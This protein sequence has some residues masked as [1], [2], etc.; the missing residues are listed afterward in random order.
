VIADF[1]GHARLAGT[2]LRIVLGRL[3]VALDLLAG[4]LPAMPPPEN[5]NAATADTAI[6]FNA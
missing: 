2:E 3:F 6:D 1:R 5:A 4:L